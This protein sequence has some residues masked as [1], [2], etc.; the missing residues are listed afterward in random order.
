MLWLAGVNV[1]WFK[2]DHCCFYVPSAAAA[3]WSDLNRASVNGVSAGSS[4]WTRPMF[5]YDSFCSVTL[6][7]AVCKG[8]TKRWNVDKWHRDHKANIKHLIVDIHNCIM[9][10]LSSIPGIKWHYW[11]RN[12]FYN[13]AIMAIHN[14]NIA[15]HNWIRV[16]IIELS[17]ACIDNAIM[18]INKLSRIMD[19][20][21]WILDI[22]I[23]IWIWILTLH[24][25][26]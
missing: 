9:D 21:N 20:R 2:S 3:R 11:I 7:F 6:W 10:I 16:C 13:H 17:I 18:D 14:A 19:I 4:A 1:V 26:L 22:S 15:M 23:T 5:W 24:I 25:Q 8:V 12:N